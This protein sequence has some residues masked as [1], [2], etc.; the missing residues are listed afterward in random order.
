MEN[1]S[2]ITKEWLH[3]EFMK[4]NIPKYYKYFDEWF[5]NIKEYQLIGF[6]EQRIGQIT[7]RNE[8]HES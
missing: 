4:S 1:E 5:S 7:K 3:R 2:L 8:K 6:E